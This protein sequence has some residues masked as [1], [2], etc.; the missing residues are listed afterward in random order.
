[1]EKIQS[2]VAAPTGTRGRMLRYVALGSAVVTAVMATSAAQAQAALGN[3]SNDL[4]VS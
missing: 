2:A 3:F 4:I 1:V